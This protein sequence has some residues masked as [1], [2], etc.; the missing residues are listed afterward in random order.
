MTKTK[1]IFIG[2]LIVPVLA[3][4]MYVGL[5]VPAEIRRNSF[6]KTVPNAMV[7][8]SFEKTETIPTEFG[9][10]EWEQFLSGWETND[11]DQ[12]HSAMEKILAHGAEMVPL[13][14]KKMKTS[15][16]LFEARLFA[17]E[18]L[19]RIDPNVDKNEIRKAMEELCASEEG[20]I[21]LKEYIKNKE[22]EIE[23]YKIA[24]EALE[25]VASRERYP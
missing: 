10:E 17:G 16:E 23:I 3:V 2:L 6:P 15:T 4:E 14:R 20:R 22:G 24:L 19:L 7:A 11:D 13:L 8:G 21:K 12:F 18:L 25:S 1:W 9:T 5:R